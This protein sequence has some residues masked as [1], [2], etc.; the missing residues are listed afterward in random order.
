MAASIF[1][2]SSMLFH[3]RNLTGESN[4]KSVLFGTSLGFAVVC[5]TLLTYIQLGQSMQYLQL[6]QQGF[7]RFF[8]SGVIIESGV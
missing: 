5:I 2:A 1:L 3:L 7:C 8:V 6:L 4:Q